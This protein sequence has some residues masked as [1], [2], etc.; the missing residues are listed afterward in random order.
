MQ[1]FHCS[2]CNDCIAITSLITNARCDLCCNQGRIVTTGDSPSQHTMPPTNTIP[3]PWISDLDSHISEHCIICRWNLNYAT[4]FLHGRTPTRQVP[5]SSPCTPGC[6]FSHPMENQRWSD[7]SEWMLAGNLLLITNSREALPSLRLL[8]IWWLI[9]GI[10]VERRGVRKK[11]NL[12][13][14]VFGHQ[15]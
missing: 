7:W 1:K 9:Q 14:L 4:F 11:S 13:L 12:L 3:T 6:C 5:C 10:D 15:E 2:H 8:N